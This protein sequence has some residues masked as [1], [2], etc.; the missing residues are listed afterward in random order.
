MRAVFLGSLILLTILSVIAWRLQP[1]DSADGR[2]TLVWV[3]DDNPARREQIA[4]FHA[5]YP[6]YRVQLD[7]SNGGVE[8]VIVQSLGGVGPDLFDCYD[9]FQLSAYVRSGVAWDITEELPR[10][11]VDI[12]ALWE[13][14]R[15][16]ALYEGRIFGFGT[17][18]SADAIWYNKDIF[19][20]EGVPYPKG[21]WKWDAFVK[22]AQ[23]MTRRDASGRVIR[24]GFLCDWWNWLHFAYQWGGRI[25]TPDGTRCIVDSPENIAAVQFLHDL[26]YRYRVMP[27]PVEEAAMATQGGWGS[28]TITRF[29]AGKAAMALGGRWWLCTLRSY[30]NLRLGVAESPHARYR[31]FRAYGKATL[32]NR[33]SPRRYEA[34]RF[35]AYQASQAYNDLI[36]RQADGIGPVARYAYTEAFLHNPAHPEEDQNHVWREAVAHSISDQVSPFVSGQ[37]AMRILSRQL[38]LVKNNQKSPAEALRTAARQINAEIART[39]EQD[40]VL[41]ARYHALAGISS[42]AGRR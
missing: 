38:D 42:G 29:G 19:D 12:N 41:R 34:L 4:L 22:L 32:I 1:T 16:Y 23:R 37:V 18:I 8:K 33:Y 21:P 24:F 25:Y 28:G 27:G 36:N 5:L 14:L 6:Q 20:A 17:N 2:V 10:L 11:G 30:R 9:G 39:L 15:S 35:L 7:P 40:P 3:S 13:P 26:I 31:I